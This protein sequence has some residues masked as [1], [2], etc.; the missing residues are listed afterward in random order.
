MCVMRGLFVLLATSGSL[1]NNCLLIMDL[2]VWG[3]SFVP[4]NNRLMR[5]QRSD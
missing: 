2:M 4:A 5:E 3:F 1:R